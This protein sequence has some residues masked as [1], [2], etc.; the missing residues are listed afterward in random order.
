[1]G[2][3]GAKEG[4]TQLVD[5]IHLQWY[6]TIAYIAMLISVAGQLQVKALQLG[7]LLL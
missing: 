4:L 2:E 6:I 1:M 3:P 5:L 7:N